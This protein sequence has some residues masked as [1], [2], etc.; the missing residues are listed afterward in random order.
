MSHIPVVPP[1]DG[2]PPTGG[3]ALRPA[4]GLAT[5]VTVLLYAVIATDLIALGADLNTRSL[6]GNLATATAQE[7]KRADALYELAGVLQG[8][9]LIATAVVFIIWFHRSRV[10]AEHYTRDVCTLGRGWAIGSWFVPIGN[11]WLPYRVAKETWQA[12][13]QSA[14]DGSW[15]TVSMAP[16]R[17]WWTLWVVSLAVSRIGAVLYHK[18]TKDHLLD[19]LRQALSVI[20]LSELLDIAAAVLAILFVRKLTRMQ[21]LPAAPYAAPHPSPQP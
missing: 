21:Q 17:A 4:K 1:Y 6:L 11:L 7:A 15:R 13:A 14:P 16:V 18:H 8:G 2:F 12:S 5:A 9:I 3:P 20:A 19:G 10:N